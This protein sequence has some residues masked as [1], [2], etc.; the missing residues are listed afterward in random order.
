MNCIPL[1]DG[2]FYG[3][4]INDDIEKCNMVYNSDSYIVT[5][6]SAKELFSSGIKENLITTDEYIGSTFCEHPREDIR[7]LYSNR[8]LTAYRL[9]ENAT[10]QSVS[11]EDIGT[12]GGIE[13]SEVENSNF[14]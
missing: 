13:K 3:E 9:I 5:K 12:L 6:E 14:V 10:D 11:H 2:G 1:E 7:N 4:K 8:K